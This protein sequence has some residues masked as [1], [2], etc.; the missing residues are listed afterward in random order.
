MN[1]IQ[2]CTRNITSGVPQ[3]SSLGPFLFL[4]NINDLTTIA[5]NNI[6][7][8][9]N[10]FFDDTTVVFLD[11][12]LKESSVV[13]VIFYWFLADELSINANKI[14]YMIFGNSKI[15]RPNIITLND[16]AISRVESTKFLVINFDENFS[17]LNT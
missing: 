5:Q 10:L 17:G 11:L 9:F 7:L 6:S 13:T 8:K 16:R 3:D 12:S 15:T 2:S 4:L 14:N 1:G